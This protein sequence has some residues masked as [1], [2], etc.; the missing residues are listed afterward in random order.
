MGLLT[1]YNGFS[2]D[3]DV[4]VSIT[5]F[6]PIITSSVIDQSENISE[7]MLAPDG[8]WGLLSATTDGAT[9]TRTDG[10]ARTNG[11]HHGLE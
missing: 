4:A 11:V 6:D 1:E 9:A 7:L 10:A 2:T 5:R 3:M 8:V